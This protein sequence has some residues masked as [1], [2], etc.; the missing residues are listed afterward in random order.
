MRRATL[1]VAC[2]VALM[3]C[4]PNGQEDDNRGIAVGNPGLL[5]V[6]MAITSDVEVIA[7]TL[8]IS[9]VE[10]AGCDEAA[11][12]STS[13]GA[14]DLALE[15]ATYDF[16]EGS[17]CGVRLNAS[18]LL[19]LEADWAPEIGVG[20]RITLDLELDDVRVGTL[21]AIDAS[22]ASEFAFELGVPDWL[23]PDLLGLVDGEDLTVEPGD[24]LHDGLV[25]ALRS[26]AALF[27]DTD[28][29]GAVEQEERDA[30]PLATAE[31]QV[32]FDLSPT[33]AGLDSGASAQACGS[34]VAG[35]GGPGLVA[36]LLLGLGRRRRRPVVAPSGH[37]HLD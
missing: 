25:D 31:I 19:H 11:Y 28:G 35:G 30:G 23:D 17:W 14:A 22:E 6:S 5:S 1:A 27:D 2:A 20:S 13:G 32:N 33:L 3:G 26:E 16:A 29:S 37:A 10:F 24:D 15:P 12:A 8:A 18:G 4:D 21:D 34:N 7:A 36:L 9:S